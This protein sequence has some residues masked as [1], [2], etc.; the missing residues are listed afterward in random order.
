MQ[1]RRASASATG[2]IAL[3][4]AASVLAGCSL[5][6][7]LIGQ[8]YSI[9]T[10]P[11]G[12]CPSLVWRFVVDPQRAISGFLSPDGLRRIANLSG[13]LAADDSFQMTATDLTGGRT[14]AVTGRFTSGISTIS[15]RGDAAGPACDGQTF[16]MRLGGY[17]AFQGGGGGG[18]G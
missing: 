4:L 15:I 18:G 12:A 14:A 16:A 7:V 8:W 6:Q 5:E 1:A 10:P 2:I 13:T 17:Y 9:V 3:L 11:A